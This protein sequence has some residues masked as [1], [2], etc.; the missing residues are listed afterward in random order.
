M[1]SPSLKILAS[2]ISKLS[3]S[4]SREAKNGFVGA[5]AV[6]FFV[7]NGDVFSTVCVVDWDRESL[8]AAAAAVETESSDAATPTRDLPS[9]VRSLCSIVR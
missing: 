3:G 1:D 5:S 6:F 7:L 8:T 2:T 9:V 4:G